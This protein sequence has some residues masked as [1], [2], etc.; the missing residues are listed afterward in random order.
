LSKKEI[1]NIGERTNIVDCFNEENLKVPE[2]DSTLSSIVVEEDRRVII[3]PNVANILVMENI[4]VTFVEFPER[5]E[6]R[7]Y[8]AEASTSCAGMERISLKNLCVVFTENFKQSS[9]VNVSDGNYEKTEAS[10][11]GQ[12]LLIILSNSYWNAASDYCQFSSSKTL[13]VS[14]SLY[15]ALFGHELNLINSAI[16][17]VALSGGVIYWLP[18]KSVENTTVADKRMRILCVL[19]QTVIDAFVV[20]QSNPSSS[21]TRNEPISSLIFVG[22]RGAILHAFTDQNTDNNEVIYQRYQLSES[23]MCCVVR[24]GRLVYSTGDELYSFDLHP[25]L[26]FSCTDSSGV[27]HLKSTCHGLR[28]VVSLSSIEST[29]VLGNEN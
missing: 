2:V 6:L 18:L 21:R 20:T 26:V 13:T 10:E 1:E 22:E 3:L 7:I 9:F 17:L 23:V 25:Q 29:D 8:R 16:L 14:D 5:L 11:N 12:K 24:C 27:R 15:N 28:K 4:L 19:E